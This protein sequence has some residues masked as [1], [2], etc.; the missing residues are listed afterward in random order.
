[1]IEV[2]NYF[3]FYLSFITL[4]IG[5]IEYFFDYD[6]Y[7]YMMLLSISELITSIIKV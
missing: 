6:K 5:S 4:I 3:L 2:Q 7:E 1:M